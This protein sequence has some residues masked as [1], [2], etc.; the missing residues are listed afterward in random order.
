MKVTILG[1][2][3]FGSALGKIVEY[4]GHEVTFY[5]PIKYPSISLDSAVSSPEAIIYVAPSD[6]H[7]DL[8][9]YLPQDTPLI[10]A[11][12]GFL[13]LTP[14]NKFT[15]FSALGGAAFAKDIE[16]S[17][18]NLR[19]TASS[20]L[21][22]RLFSTEKITVEYT[23]DTLGILLCGALKNIYAIG[24]GLFGD[25]ENAE[26]VSMP[27]LE[28]VISE[29]QSILKVNGSSSEVLKL[30]C[31]APDLLLSCSP[32]SRNF[33]FG[34]SLKNHTKSND[35]TVEGLSVIKS[36]NEYPEFTIP[37][38]ATILKDIINIIEKEV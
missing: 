14:F 6:Q 7:A 18:K 13:S 30:S 16:N 23:A 17:K 31:G 37:N 9:P 26:A 22:E 5:D 25:S 21:S 36:L 3:A 38:S 4:N 24:A 27:Y 34:L 1:A 20:S 33:R 10:C 15:N 8:L 32:D 12:K 11:S 19:L 35:A 28:S 2:G 29:M